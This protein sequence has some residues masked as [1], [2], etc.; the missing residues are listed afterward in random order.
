MA[1]ADK[2][3]Y[4]RKLDRGFGLLGRWMAD[5]RLVVFAVTFALLGAAG[6]FAGQARTDNSFDA[7]F[8][9]TDPSYQAYQLYQQDFGSDEVTYILYR[10]P[11]NEN[12]PF[13]L[14]VMATIAELT[15]VLESEVPFVREVTSLTSVE[16]MQAHDD[17]LEITEL[18]QELPETQAALLRHRDA[19]LKKPLYIG[20][21]VTA[22]ASHG[23]IILEMSA[24][25]SDSLDS[26]RLDPNGG[27]G[28]ENLYPQVSNNRVLEILARPEYTGIE[29]WWSGDVPM[30]AAYNQTITDESALLAL[31]SF[32]VAAVI[33]LFCFRGQ[34]LGLVGP[35]AVVIVALVFT[36]GFMGLAGYKLGALFLIA[37]TLL[38]AIGV[39]QSVHLISE[40][41]RLREQGAQRGEAIQR[42]LENVAV[43]CLLAAVTTAI[44]F[45][46]MAGSH[47]RALAEMAVYLSAGVMLSFVA[48]VTV[49]VC[50]M[51]LGRNQSTPPREPA[52]REAGIMHRLLAALVT[53]NLKRRYSIVAVSAVLLLFALAGAS[54][55]QVSFN[56]LEDFK[57]HTQY[58]QHTNYL[59]DIMGGM[60]NVVFI[61]QADE[62]EAVKS[63]AILAHLE[64]LQ[65]RAEQSPLVRK[66]YSVV[67]ILKDINQSFHGDDLD[68]HRL[69]DS[70]EL[71]AQYLLL[72]EL[73]GGGELEDYVSGDYQR[74][75]LELRVDMVDSALLSELIAE[76][77]EYLQ[78]N[79]A[80]QAQ[81]KITGIGVLWL[82]MSEYIA[83]SQIQGYAL[84]F[85]FIAIVLCL[86][87]RSV[88]VG[89]LAM[90][91]N[92]FPVVF[93]L[94]VVGEMGMH[95]DYFRLLLATVAI[96]IAVD[97]TVHMTSRIRKE[98][99]H[100]GNY[101]EAIRIGLMNV[102]RPVITTSIILSLSFLVYLAS[103]MAILA[104][105]GILLSL[106]IVLAL[107]ADLFLLP[108]L[109]LVLQPFG[110]E[111][112]RM[113]DEA[114]SRSER[115]ATA[116]KH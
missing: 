27:D 102:G 55:L 113:A 105:F 69:P 50:I 91:P 14:R 61:Y 78:E 74:T 93:I 10:V 28:L 80:P 58:R 33:A 4:L 85:I 70:D 40:F 67:D 12:G 29:F 6:Y 87:F 15:R 2:P 46:V 3:D 98:F 26:I 90:I 41:S 108:A 22:D 36:V 17:F 32:A 45:A 97:D 37:P 39:A 49:M 25:S 106:T 101:E 51:S 64:A 109:V 43:P 24:S 30:N 114:E 88:K 18:G 75:T 38:T 1:R 7:Y 65:N 59:Q 82:K 52:E 8:D 34:W 84:A 16:F 48:S 11:G 44:G 104:S 60:L 111:R 103:D 21:L 86:A 63:R 81:V 13:D 68:Y 110:S 57:A 107:L 9:A 116:K 20:S 83:Q 94:G 112:G 71:I 23:A 89:L 100:C 72:Y 35:L 47:L 31:L 19:M 76:L 62:P 66:T 73:S 79:P 99:I 92:L 115:L 95:L 42:T 54:K 77:S 53:F 5:H 56:Y 96:G